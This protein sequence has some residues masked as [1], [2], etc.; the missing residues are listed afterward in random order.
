MED[1][2][3]QV[4][5][6]NV[7][8]A[9]FL[10]QETTAFTATLYIDGKRTATI[11]NNGHGGSNNIYPDKPGDRAVIQAFRDWAEALPPLV[12][13]QFGTLPMN[14]DLFIGQLL[15]KHMENKQIKGWCRRGIVLCEDGQ[16]STIKRPFTHAMVP[17]LNAK[18]PKAEIVNL[19]FA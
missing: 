8:V 6:K 4:E 19:R 12:D 14:E 1:E 2:H 11:S 10:S 13:E 17:A 5:L 16:Y 9:E 3:M 15:E 7:K 18:Y